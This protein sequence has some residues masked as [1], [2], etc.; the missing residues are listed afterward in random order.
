[1]SGMFAH[2]HEDGAEHTVDLD[3]DNFAD[4]MGTSGQAPSVTIKQLPPSTPHVD[5][6][7]G[8]WAAEIFRRLFFMT[9]AVLAVGMYVAFLV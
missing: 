6:N 8:H 9:S 5:H 2:H 7:C 4:N 1:M 3:D